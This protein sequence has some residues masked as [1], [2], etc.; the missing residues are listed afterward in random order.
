[1]HHFEECRYLW[2]QFPICGSDTSSIVL[3]KFYP[4]VNSWVSGDS[5]GET[6]ERVCSILARE[7]AQR[8]AEVYGVTFS[9]CQCLS[10]LKHFQP[11]FQQFHCKAADLFGA[12]LASQTSNTL[13]KYLVNPVL[14]SLVGSFNSRCVD[15]TCVSRICTKFE[16]C[17]AAGWLCLDI[18]G[19][20]SC[21]TSCRSYLQVPSISVR[22]Q[23]PTYDSQ[24]ERYKKA[25]LC[26]S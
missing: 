1:M 20:V 17:K 6:R 15:R 7:N 9:R 24:H 26:S 23:C 18:S 16:S 12:S 10:F 14:C 11:V 8:N 4:R 21:Q 3:L 5:K 13:E 2:P 25:L 22:C 19:F